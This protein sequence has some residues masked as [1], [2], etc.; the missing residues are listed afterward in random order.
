[1]CR[2]RYMYMHACTCICICVYNIETKSRLKSNWNQYQVLSNRIDMVRREPPER[3]AN[4]RV[5]WWQIQLPWWSIKCPLWQIEL[6]RRDSL[7]AYPAAGQPSI[8]SM[9][10]T[11]SGGRR[12]PPPSL[13]VAFLIMDGCLEAWYARRQSHYGNLITL[14]FH[15]CPAKH[16]PWEWAGHRGGPGPCKAYVCTCMY[17]YIMCTV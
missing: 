3:C 6:P 11:S 7:L 17:G 5:V 1:M 12:R 10:R 4:R 2:N 13:L 16:T 8:R 15:S 14:W 9:I